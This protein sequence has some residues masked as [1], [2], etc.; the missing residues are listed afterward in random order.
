MCATLL[1]FLS[2]C[3]WETVRG[4]KP[5][6]PKSGFY[7]DT[8]D[9]LQPELKWKGD[10]ESK[11]YDL[12]IWNTIL[13][14]NDDGKKVPMRRKIIYKKTALSGTAHKVELILDP[15]SLYF[16]SVRETGSGTWSIERLDIPGCSTTRDVFRFYTPKAN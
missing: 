13:V 11:K 4:V 6:Y 14:A 9:S 8:V 5:V 10:S 16:W 15:G 12:A 3:A 2:G 1:I 7:P